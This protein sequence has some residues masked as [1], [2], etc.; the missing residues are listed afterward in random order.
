MKIYA[1]MTLIL[2]SVLLF[3]PFVTLNMKEAPTNG[4]SSTS[5]VSENETV[6]VLLTTSGN[7]KEIPLNEYL[8]GVVAAEMPASFE[9]EALKA[10]AVAS[11]TYEK[12]LKENAEESSAF[13]I[14]DSSS[15]NQ[16]YLSEEDRKALWQNKFESYNEKITNAVNSVLGEYLSYDGKTALTL[17]HAISPGKTADC[18][19]VFGEAL[20][21]LE[22]V[23][24]PGDKLSPDY[25]TEVSF[26]K[27]EALAL[28]NNN[29]PE[30]EGRD[31]SFK[32][33][34][35]NE[36]GY[37][38]SAAVCK[39]ELSNK[40][41]RNI[42]SLPSLYFTARYEKDTLVFTVYGKGHGVGMSQ[43]SA[44]YMARQSATY[45]DILEYFYK[46]TKISAR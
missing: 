36:N 7:T 33:T 29:S 5:V 25:V 23:T 41:L 30:T 46:G 10:Q 20:A 31:F 42:F 32:I 9:T 8:V 19:D 34:D 22:S 12:Y 3:L 43:Y 2:S 14:T 16:A 39:K 35:S 44:D 21:Y 26:L 1:I 24:A 18:K 45:K 6:K 17:Y 11:Y 37:V 13:Y 40:D 28:I 15:F 38:V 27:K 4:P